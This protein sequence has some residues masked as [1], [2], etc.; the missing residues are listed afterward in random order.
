MFWLVGWLELIRDISMV[1]IR[2]VDSSRFNIRSSIM[3]SSSIDRKVIKDRIGSQI[4]SYKEVSQCLVWR[5]RTMFI[6]GSRKKG[7]R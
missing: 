6:I 1:R 5:F 4:N 2:S 7:R 3:N